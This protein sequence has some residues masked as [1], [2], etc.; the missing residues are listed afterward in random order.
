MRSSFKYRLYPNR[1]QSEVLDAMLEAHRRLYNLALRERRDMYEAEVHSVSYGEQS[2]RFKETRKV[3]SSFAALNFSSAQA[4]LRRLDRAFKAFFRRVKSG[5]ARHG[6]R[7]GYPRFKPEERFKTV[8]FPSYGD[9]CRLK[10]NGRLYLQNIGHIKVK[11]HRPGEGT[12]K[13]VS[14]KRS[15]G[16]WYV[17]FSCDL[18]DAP[19]AAADGPAVGIDLGL[20]SFLV[21]SEGNSVQPPR[22]YRESEK[23][24]R[25]TQRSVSRKKKGSNRRRKA[26][27]KVARL[28]EKTANQRRDFHHRLTRK[29][30]DTHSVIVHEALNI[31]GFARSRLAKST[32]DA[33]W[34]SFLNILSYKAEEAGTRVVAVDPRNTT[35]ACSSCGTMPEVKKTLSGRI[36]ACPCGYTDDRDVN[37]ALNILSLGW[38][39]QAQTHRDAGR[40]A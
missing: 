4:T 8:E 32:H 36:H 6:C 20:K 27:K 40:V 18:G 19:E 14:V 2:S 30:V 11:L 24:L 17:I 3:L 16:K 1:S 37:A 34:A 38:S 31:K 33:G 23:K 7:P 13:T 29:L 28:H 22:Y 9:G 26:Q 15:C 25:K 12:I 5:N 10:N 35:Q 39:D 21:T